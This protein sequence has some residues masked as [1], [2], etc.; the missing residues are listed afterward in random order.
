MLAEW[1][2]AAPADERERMLALL[3]LAPVATRVADIE[4][5]QMRDAILAA[6]YESPSRMVMIPIQ[7]LFGWRERINLPGTVGPANWSW[8]LPLAIEDISQDPVSSAQVAQLRA[9]AI[10]A[11]R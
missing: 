2:D 7:D 6:L 1:W 5:E 11:G 4:F 10:K 3:A 8:R 9:M